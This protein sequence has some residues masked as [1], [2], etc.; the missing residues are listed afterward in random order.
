MLATALTYLRYSTIGQHNRRRVRI[1]ALPGRP[2][3]DAYALLLD[4]GYEVHGLLR[5][6]ASADV[7]NSRL[8][9]LGVADRVVLHDGNL[10]DVSSLMRVLQEVRPEEIYHLAAHAFGGLDLCQ[11]S[12]HGG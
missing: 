9:W 12:S 5:R 8:I 11:W 10:V 3:G 1:S 2:R 4:Q 7:V 6:S